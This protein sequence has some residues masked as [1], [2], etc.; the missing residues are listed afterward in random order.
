M[1]PSLSAIEKRIISCAKC[2]EL[3]AYCEAVALEKK[4]AYRDQVYWG[5]P[6]PAFGDPLA[7]VMLLGLAPGAHGSN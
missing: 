1:N 2:P 3:R 4:R 7:R 6:V 5:K